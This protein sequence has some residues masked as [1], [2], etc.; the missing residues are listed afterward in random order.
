MSVLLFHAFE[1]A[2]EGTCLM[3]PSTVYSEPCAALSL[4]L[5][6][7]I[8]NSTTYILHVL[9]H[10]YSYVVFVRKSALSLMTEWINICAQNK[11]V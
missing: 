1:W 2:L 3:A 10:G 5:C 11:S 9:T 8:L 6:L 4:V 7:I